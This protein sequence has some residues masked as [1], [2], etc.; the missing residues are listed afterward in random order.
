LAFL[1]I[2]RPQEIAELRQGA[3][4]LFD[5]FELAAD[6]EYMQAQSDLDTRLVRAVSKYWESVCDYLVRKHVGASL[7]PTRLG[8]FLGRSPR[9]LRAIAGPVARL[10]INVGT[11]AATGVIVPTDLQDAADRSLDAVER[12]FSLRFLVVTETSEI[13]RLRS[14]L[15]DRSWIS[16]GRPRIYLP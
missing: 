11:P 14:M 3:A 2:L 7:R 16:A 5:L 8:I 15:P 9:F 10:A 4:D 13:R 1:G 12:D 6:P